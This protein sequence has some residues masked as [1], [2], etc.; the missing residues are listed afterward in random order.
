MCHT[1][2]MAQ[3]SPEDLRLLNGTDEVSIERRPGRGT[4]IWIVVADGVAYIRSVRGA[5][6]LWYQ[7]VSG[8]S[9]ARLVAGS[10]AWPIRVEAVSDPAQVERVSEAIRTKYER[11]WPGPT[12]AML[13]PEVVSTTLRVEPVAQ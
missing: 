4:T 12:A 7:T 10:A 11:R 5:A 1:G 9:P 2:R 8:G 3:F 6:G 13:R